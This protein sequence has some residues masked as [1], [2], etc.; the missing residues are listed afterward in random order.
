[1]REF[2]LLAGICLEIQSLNIGCGSDPWDDVR[3]DIAFK[4]ITA[5]F[6]PTVLAD[7]HYLLFKSGFFKI[8]K[9]SHVLE[10]L[11]DLLRH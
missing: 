9:A 2:I 8:A 4:F 3:V 6:K 10:H 11:R 5:C 1:M 7:A